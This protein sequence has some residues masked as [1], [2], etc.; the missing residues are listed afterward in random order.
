MTLAI[1]I[2]GA[3]GLGREVLQILR[4]QQRV[5]MQVD[6]LGFLVDP[7]FSGPAEIHGVPVHHNI[8]PLAA[9]QSV[10]FVVAI[11]NPLIRSSIVRKIR[12]SIG[13]RFATIVHPSCILGDTVTVGSGSILLPAASITTD[14]RIGQHVLINPQ[15]SIAHDCVVEDYVS[16]GPKVSLAGGVHLE[17]GCELGTAATVIPRQRVGR[18]AVVGAGAVVIDPVMPNV[19]VVGVP[20]RVVQSGKADNQ[21]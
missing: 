12:S 17:K 13:S 11:G 18:W 3:G 5:G 2:F 7:Q 6:C 1:V 15:V 8:A 4:E 14:V 10:R 19:T 21:A 9:D 16:L 20:A